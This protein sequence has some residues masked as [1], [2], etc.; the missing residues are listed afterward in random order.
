L[1]VVTNP[2]CRGFST[3]SQRAA[4]QAGIPLVHFDDFLDDLGT[5]WA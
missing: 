2:N 1:I 4:A 5:K 3:D